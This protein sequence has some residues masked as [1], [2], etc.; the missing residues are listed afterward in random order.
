M[1]SWKCVDLH[2]LSLVF[3]EPCSVVCGWWYFR[4]SGWLRV[5][6]HLVPSK[7]RLTATA[8]IELWLKACTMNGLWPV[9]Y[10]R[11]GGAHLQLIF[12]LCFCLYECFY[13]FRRWCVPGNLCSLR[14]RPPADWTCQLQEYCRCIAR[15]RPRENLRFS[16]VLISAECFLLNEIAASGFEE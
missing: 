8:L 2:F 11:S 7:F 6:R 15:V 16:L 4:N 9:C 10:V 1:W 14:L 12:H 13:W 5:W 3:M